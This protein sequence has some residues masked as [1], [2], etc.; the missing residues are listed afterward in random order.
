M[1]LQV[2]KLIHRGHVN[3]GLIHLRILDLTQE[4]KEHLAE[5]V[6]DQPVK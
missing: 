4:L 6:K 2:E 1:V 3:P 5:T